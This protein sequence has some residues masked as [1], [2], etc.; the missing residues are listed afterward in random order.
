MRGNSEP[1]D[2]GAEN[3]IYPAGVFG[4]DSPAGNWLYPLISGL[5]VFLLAAIAV[6]VLTSVWRERTAA[7]A[8]S[9]EAP[10]DDAGISAGE[11][12]DR[13]LAAGEITIAEYEQVA[14]VLSRRHAQAASGAAAT[15]GSVTA[16]A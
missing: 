12:L 15:N 9:D 8:V 16:A 1:F 14:E 7:G 13:R 2:A 11:I 10:T 3:V 4:R 5:A 6:Y